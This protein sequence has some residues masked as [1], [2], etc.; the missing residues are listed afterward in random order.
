MARQ[1]TTSSVFDDYIDMNI[2]I[3]QKLERLATDIHQSE[4]R[5]R[6]Y[7]NNKLDAHMEQLRHVLANYKSS[8]PSSSSR[9]RRSSRTS[10]E[11]PSDASTS[12]PRPHLRDDR[13]NNHHARDLHHREGQATSR[14]Q[15]REDQEHHRGQASMPRS[16]RSTTRMDDPFIFGSI[17]RKMA[18]HGI[19]LRSWRRVMMCHLR[20]SSTATMMRWLSMGFVLRPWRRLEMS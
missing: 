18:E 5:K 9:R 15:V 7:F 11:R 4:A 10:S 20:P 16:R 17:P 14:K 13:H 3:D 12:R 2:Y 1:S 19:T 6:D 8:S